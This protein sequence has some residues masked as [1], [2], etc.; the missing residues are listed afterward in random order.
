[1]IG[2]LEV[3]RRNSKLELSMSR[4][5]G[6]LF[7][8]LIEPGDEIAIDCPVS[9]SFPERKLREVRERPFRLMWLVMNALMN[10]PAIAHF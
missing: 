10:K 4:S 3:E 9:D 6:W 8:R 5:S 7:R 2:T 1:M